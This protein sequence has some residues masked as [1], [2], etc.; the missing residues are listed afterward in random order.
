M[1]R[2]CLLANRHRRAVGAVPPHHHAS[3]ATDLVTGK[4]FAL[5]REYDVPTPADTFVYAVL[6]PYVNPGN[7]TGSA[8]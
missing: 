1:L 5:G 4:V 8:T 2:H 6:K 7:P 3:T